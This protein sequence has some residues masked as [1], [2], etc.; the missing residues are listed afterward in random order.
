MLLYVVPSGMETR[1]LVL[2]EDAAGILFI[3]NHV[4]HCGVRSMR[5]L[6]CVGLGDVDLYASCGIS[7]ACQVCEKRSEDW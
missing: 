5:Q 2:R 7:F 3:I 6:S 4:V 1:S